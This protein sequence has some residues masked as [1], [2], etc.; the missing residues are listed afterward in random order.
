MRTVADLRRALI[1][2]TAELESRVELA[3][4]RRLAQRR[5]LAKAGAAA[6]AAV[7]ALVLALYAA[8]GARSGIPEP[9]ASD[10]AHPLPNVP[11]HVHP[12]FPSVGQV[13]GTGVPVGPGQEFV[14][15]FTEGPTLVGGLLDT[16][17]G[18]VRDL[19]VAYDASPDPRRGGG[20]QSLGQ[21]VDRSGGVIEYGLYIGTVSRIVVD[22]G[23]GRYPAQLAHWSQDPRYTVF[24]VDHRGTPVEAGVTNRPVDSNAHQPTAYAYDRAEHQAGTTS[25]RLFIRTD[26]DINLSDAAPLGASIDTGVPLPDGGTL[27]FWFVGGDGSAILK[28]GSRGAT[29]RVTEIRELLTIP[30]PP[31]A[32]GFYR[33]MTDLPG[34]NGT[35]IMVGQYVGPAAKVVAGAPG[36]NVTSGF[37]HWSAHPEMIV[38]WAANV[39]EYAQT[40]AIAYDSTQH[41]IGAYSYGTR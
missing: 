2:E 35:H 4:V 8:T 34:R 33:G 17:T 6:A 11:L 19:S 27:L 15:R 26:L 28:A 1:E 25:G 37:A 30:V 41:V 20:F 16:R 23:I 3:G 9:L 5:R 39:T 32:I 7:V 12:S 24:W 38:Y 13:I 22:S 36:G 40:A 14:L 29:G 10:S 31:S 18:V 21:L